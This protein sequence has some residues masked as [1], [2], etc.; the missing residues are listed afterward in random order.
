MRRPYIGDVFLLNIDTDDPLIKKYCGKYVLVSYLP[1]L[2][3][4]INMEN[5]SLYWNHDIVVKYE[6][7]LKWAD[8]DKI[9]C[10]KIKGCNATYCAKHPAT[11]INYDSFKYYEDTFH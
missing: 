7:N 1:Q 8:I 3:S 5:F 2:V 6:N 10:K 9:F 4:L 11:I